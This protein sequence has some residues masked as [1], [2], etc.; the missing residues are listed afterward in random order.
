MRVRCKSTKCSDGRIPSLTIG[1]IYEVIGIEADDFRVIDDAGSPVLFEP[2][3]FDIVDD[4]RSPDWVSEIDDGVEYAGPPEF[5][6]TGFWEDF[7]DQDPVA[8]A[9]F[10]RYINRHLRTTDAA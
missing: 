8:Q 3:L 1:E 6:A 4:T 10:S 9:T 5:A 2:D 7:F